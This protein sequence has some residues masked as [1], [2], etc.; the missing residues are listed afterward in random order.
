MLDI[1]RFQCYAVDERDVVT[2]DSA[3]A[4]DAVT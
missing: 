4:R 2:D 3:T 1:D